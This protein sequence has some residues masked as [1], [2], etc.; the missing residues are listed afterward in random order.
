[1][2]NSGDEELSAVIRR[3]ILIRPMRI[4]KSEISSPNANIVFSS[5]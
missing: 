5:V 2:E 3:W 1:M 4:K